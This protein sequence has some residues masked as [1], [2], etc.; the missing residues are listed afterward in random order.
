MGAPGFLCSSRGL[1]SRCFGGY[2]GPQSCYDADVLLPNAERAFID[3]RKLA[4]Y[5][6]DLTHP[7]GFHKAIVFRSALGFT[8][9]DASVLR[10]FLPRRPRLR[11]CRWAHR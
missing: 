6:L 4:E 9:R 10:D 7:V 8:S 5:S 2:D 1:L 11:G 3:F